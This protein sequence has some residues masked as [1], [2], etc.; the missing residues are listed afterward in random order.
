M[1]YNNI[2]GFNDDI[3]KLQTEEEFVAEHTHLPLSTDEL[4]NIHATILKAPIAVKE[5][6]DAKAKE[7]KALAEQKAAQDKLD[8]REKKRQELAS[9]NKT[10][11]TSPVADAKADV[12]KSS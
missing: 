1:K 11:K 3:A 4:K 12:K 9:Q 10:T 5:E 7:E 8:A 6:T 2:Y